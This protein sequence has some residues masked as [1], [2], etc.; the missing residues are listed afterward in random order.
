MMNIL[1]PFNSPGHILIA[2]DSSTQAQRLQYI[3]ERQGY[4]V[5]VASNGR[6]A[7]EMALQI[8]PSLVISDVIMPEMDGYE[9]CR[10]IKA[11]PDSSDLPVILVTSMSSPED[12]ILGLECGADNFIIKPYEERY[13]LSRVQY[14]LVN[15]EFQGSPEAS[16]GVE[17]YFNSRRHYITAGRL[18]ILN[19]LLSTYEAAVQRND[20]LA[21][22]QQA[23]EAR[24]AE[25]AAANRFLDSIIENIPTM[26]FI[27]DT[28]S[29]RHTRFNRAGEDLTGYSRE[30]ILG[31]TV[32]DLF[33]PEQAEFFHSTD[34]DTIA[35]GVIRDVCDEHIRTANRGDRIL[36]TKKVPI[37]DRYGHP[38]HLL[39]ISEDV[40]EQRA[41]ENE[42]RRLNKLLEERAQRLE[43][44]NEE[45]QEA[46]NY[47]ALFDRLTELPNRQLFLERA[48][49]S[50]QSTARTG[51][52]VAVVVVDVRR[53]GM[54]NDSF[55]TCGGDQA[56]RLIAR[57]LSQ[58]IGAICARIGSNTF[59]IAL[60]NLSEDGQVAAAL[61]RHVLAPFRQPFFI[62]DQELAV[63]IRCGVALFPNDGET[64]DQL[65]GNA[66]AALKKAKLNNKE[67]L[68]YTPDLNARV[69]EQLILESQ[70][71]RAIAHQE[72][73]LHYQP[74]VAADNGKLIGFEALLRWCSPDRGMVAPVD[75]I[76]LL[77]ETG[78]ILDVGRWVLQQAAADYREWQ[79]MGLKPVPIAV[80]LS[81]I[82]MRQADFAEA[83]I[84]ST[85]GSS[86]EDAPAIDLEITESVL[87]EDIDRTIPSLQRLREA[88]FHI[89]ID[90]FGTGY[91][92]FS[93]L[94]KIPLD[95]IKID[96][97]FVKEMTTN[98]SQ[99]T[100]VSTIILLAHALGLTVIAEGVETEDQ[101]AQLL[102]IGCDEIQ[103]YLY[104]KPM[105]AAE[106]IRLLSCL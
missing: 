92:S 40:T 3:L 71:R 100:V 18:Q 106:V 23:L 41:M 75:F 38:T 34:L 66:E 58:D 55:G 102:S 28:D 5:S 60:P 98:A 82:Q 74:K 64:I 62:A 46:L 17:V 47:L 26:V 99:K 67:Y 22:S 97:S 1:S 52:K 16:M 10:R 76:P 85:S 39:G 78:M 88:G 83:I 95:S 101:R 49:Q 80:N 11:S 33:P 77:E 2:E 91:S 21:R 19:L 42:I 44:S 35:S 29:F 104:G 25:L 89:A 48:T 7:L 65:I 36:H 31:K 87:M 69:S 103:G 61:N 79:K 68:F 12:V 30:A 43:A 24:S 72:F 37:F 8:K 15:R 9:L 14:V 53:L 57:R 86:G 50:L 54:I 93:Y 94:T 90:D 105:P 73:V 81:A 4:Q 56:L 96:R 70:L 59:A 32:F 13:L 63:S 45:K 27:K 6:L 84:S 20:E 51:A